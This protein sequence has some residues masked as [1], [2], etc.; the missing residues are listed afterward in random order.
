MA[1]IGSLRNVLHTKVHTIGRHSY[2]DFELNWWGE[3]K[4]E[5]G[6]FCSIGRN[7]KAYLGGNHRHTYVSTFPFGIHGMTPSEIGIDNKL[8][9]TSN[10]NIVIGNDVWFGD[11]CVV[12]SGVTI[13][14]GAVIANSALV[15][16]DV[17]PY[18]IVGGNPAKHIKY[19]FEPKI[20]EAL[21]KI[22]WW[23]WTDE[24]INSRKDK[25]YNSDIESFV[26]EFGCL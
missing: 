24:V 16:K 15:T 6:S 3:S 8:T 12:M 1:Y 26:K 14:H 25:I 22:Q 2:G 9:N 4:I 10:G 5:I 21:L 23:D 18:S 7:N 20:I 17:E 19:R 13:G 11:N